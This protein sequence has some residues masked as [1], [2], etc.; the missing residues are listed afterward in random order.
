MESKGQNS[1]FSEHGHVAYE[2]KWNHE[3]SN[4]GNVMSRLIHILFEF[5]SCSTGSNVV[6]VVVVADTVEVVTVAMGEEV[7]TEE[8][9]VEEADKKG[10]TR[11][12][13]TQIQM[14]KNSANCSSVAYLL[15]LQK[16]PLKI[17][18]ENMEKL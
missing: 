11:Q 5:L 1:T 2:I 15:K 6:M 17:I 12:I 14:L 4:I 18:L 8:E 3:C 16:T 13:G 10:T 9:E 7:A